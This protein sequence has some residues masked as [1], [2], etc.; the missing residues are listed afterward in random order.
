MFISI[1]I[2]KSAAILTAVGFAAIIFGLVKLSVSQAM[3]NGSEDSGI[4]LPIIMYHSVVNG[5][6]DTGDYVISTDELTSDI[7]YLLKEGYTPIFCSEAAEYVSGNGTLPENPVILSFDD[8][9]YNNFY[10]V[11]PILEKYKVKAVFSIVGEWC[12]IASEDAAP[13]PSYSSMDPENVKTLYLS[14]YCEIANHTWSMHSLE[15][16]RGVL[17]LDGESES[18][19]RRAL[20]NDVTE[21]QRL[22]RGIGCEPYIF[23]YPYGFSNEL[24]ERIIS[25]LGFKITLGCEE[26]IN[27]LTVGDNDCLLNMGRFNRPGGVSSEEFFSELF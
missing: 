6:S 24:T 26:K 20:Y 23:T 2:F 1:K 27:V 9:C 8:G 19:Y 25:E 17:Q 16:R 15:D 12:S 5:E 10:Y 4:R 3:E 13:S 18:D 21:T 7:E 22:L 14:G 11:L